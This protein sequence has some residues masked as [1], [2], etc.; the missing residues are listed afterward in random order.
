MD[1]NN[2]PRN[3][4]EEEPGGGRDRGPLKLWHGLLL[5][6]LSV[7]LLFFV[8]S[9]AQYYWGLWGMALT[10]LGIAATTLLFVRIYKADI[11]E[12]FPFN[13][14]R[15]RH[16]FGSLSAIAGA[17]LMVIGVNAITITVFPGLAERNLEVSGF[18][19]QDAFWL[20][21]LA[22][23]VLPGVCEEMMHRGFIFASSGRLTRTWVRVLYMGVVFGLFHADLYRFLPTALIGMTLTYIMIRTRN[24]ALP[25]LCHFCNNMLGV[26][27]SLGADITD[28]E[29]DAAA[30]VSQIDVSMGLFFIGLGITPLLI[31]WVLLR[32]TSKKLNTAAIV[33]TV[34]AAFALTVGSIVAMLPAIY[35]MAP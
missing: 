30:A 29:L 23:A 20:R 24:I 10:E 12:V 11:R 5:L 35:D 32:D 19:A 8:F 16:V 6:G 28:V 15:G 18:I 33:L 7:F 31:G 25:M 26:L 21:L 1:V 3:S 13:R 14:V 27:V 34:L 4:F 17:Y 22:A 2:N 9:I